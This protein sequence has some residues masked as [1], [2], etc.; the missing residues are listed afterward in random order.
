MTQMIDK[1]MQ[2]KERQNIET[3]IE[4]T[5]TLLVSRDLTLQW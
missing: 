2:M 1:K 5:N 3:I 4:S